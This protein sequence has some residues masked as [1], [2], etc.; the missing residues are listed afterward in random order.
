MSDLYSV[1][2][3]L[4][5]APGVAGQLF[6]QGGIGRLNGLFDVLRLQVGFRQCT[7]GRE[8][9]AAGVVIL[10]LEGQGDVVIALFG[11]VNLK[12]EGAV[13]VGTNKLIVVGVIHDALDGDTL[14]GFAGNH[15]F[16][17]A[18]LSGD[19]LI[20]IDRQQGGLIGGGFEYFFLSY[21]RTVFHRNGHEPHALTG[22]THLQGELSG[23]VDGILHQNAV[24]GGHA[25][26]Y[27]N[28]L[29]TRRACAGYGKAAGVGFGR[30]RGGE[31]YFPNSRVRLDGDTGK[32]KTGHD[33]AQGIAV[34]CF[35][36]AAIDLI[37]QGDGVAIAN[38][39]IGIASIGAAISGALVFQG[40][41]AAI[42]AEL[43]PFGGLIGV[44]ICL[45]GGS[46]QV[47]LAES[48]AAGGILLIQVIILLRII[49]LHGGEDKASHTVGG[50]SYQQNP[51][52]PP[53]LC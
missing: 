49:I 51:I 5:D 1:Q 18:Q 38:R 48:T 25:H 35:Q 27:A 11:G 4:H 34:G 39:P 33:F 3:V 8:G 19:F 28:D 6:R 40:Q 26:H 10:L 52:R 42:G 37:I 50:V 7:V 53:L 36:A 44:A 23:L 41:K 43:L 9:I 29:Q 32:G 47:L 2:F 30:G 15:Q 17:A 13:V 12:G 22:Q 14:N 46:F 24:V 45:I 31:G 16:V 20:Q 21:G